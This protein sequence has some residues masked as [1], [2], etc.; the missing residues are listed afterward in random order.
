MEDGTCV[1]CG[2]ELPPVAL[3]HNDPFCSTNC[4]NIYFGSNETTL[5]HPPTPED[6][7]LRAMARDE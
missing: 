1:I 5:R 7:L 2:K 6:R 4:A 3:A